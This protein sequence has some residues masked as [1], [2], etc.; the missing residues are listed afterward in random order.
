MHAVALYNR[1]IEGT[2]TQTSGG[3]TIKSEF[4]IARQ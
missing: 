4:K 2:W 3:K 1:W